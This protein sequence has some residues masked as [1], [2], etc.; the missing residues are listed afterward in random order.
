MTLQVDS[1]AAAL[2]S[3]LLDAEAARHAQQ[4]EPEQTDVD[5]AALREGPDLSLRSVVATGGPGAIALLFGLNLV[6]EFDRTALLV[7]GPDIQSTFGLSDAQLGGLNGVGAVLVVLGAVPLGLLADRYRRGRLIAVA[8]LF[9]ATAAAV[10]GLARSAW[11]LVITRALS[12][13]AKGAEPVHVSLLADAY[14]IAGRARV[15]AMYGMA[16]PI[17][18]AIGP[19][20]AGSVAA[21]AGGTQ[22]WRWALAVLSVPALILGIAALWLKEPVRGRFEQEAVRGVDVAPPL[23]EEEPISL[24]AGFARLKQIKTYSYLMVGIGA[25]GFAAFGAPTL[26]NLLLEREYG[27]GTFDRGLVGSLLA[28]GSLVGYPLGGYFGD[29]LFRSDPTRLVLMIGLPIAL[30][31][32]VYPAALFLPSLWMV[33]TGLCLASALLSFALVPIRTLVAAIVPYRLRGLGFSLLGVYLVLFGGFVGGIIA[34]SLSDAFGERTAL[35]LSILPACLVGGGVIGYAARFVRRDLAAIVEELTEERDE[36]RRS[37]DEPAEV[38]VLQVRNIDFSYGNV[39]VLFDVALEVA[40]GEVLALLGTNGAGKSTILR[41]ISGLSVPSRGVVRLE[42]RTISYL[43]AEARVRAGIVQVSGGKAVF[44]G[45]TVEEN[46]RVG[47]YQH[48]SDR[49]RV[50]DRIAYVLELFPALDAR[51]GQRAGT[52]SGGEQQMVALAKAMMLEPRILLIDELSLGLAPVVV[53]DLLAVIER[54]R[55]TGLAMIIVEQSVNVALSIAD[56]AVFMEKGQVR[57]SGAAADLL[58]RDDL[59]RAVFLGGEVG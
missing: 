43:E 44:P 50:D 42:G 39:Q 2:A 15:F 47:A 17:G 38:P 37:A 31:G 14:P 18:N 27:L 59:V 36:A 10:G 34:G 1:D 26:F 22:G 35:V 48:L 41:V 33:L 46:L 57:F 13:F 40:P 12:G 28:L 16:T 58:E 7:L 5:D 53:Q 32:I 49:R 23:G 29:R 30:F 3:G 52:L 54:L 55:E 21:I 25:L 8:A 11:Q 24:A 56:R 4:V 19:F 20:L 51:M 6:D 45:L 9:W